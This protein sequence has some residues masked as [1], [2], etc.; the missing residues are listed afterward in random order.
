M[1]WSS[2]KG[3]K[4]NLLSAFYVP[5]TIPGTGNTVSKTKILAFWEFTIWWKEMVSTVNKKNIRLE[6]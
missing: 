2:Q 6:F 1:L 5:H 4:K 3:K